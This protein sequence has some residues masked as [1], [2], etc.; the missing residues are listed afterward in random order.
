MTAVSSLSSL[1][2]LASWD[3][4]STLSSDPIQHSTAIEASNSIHVCCGSLDDELDHESSSES[5]EEKVKKIDIE[6]RS[7]DGVTFTLP[8]EFAIS[9]SSVIAATL[10]F[11]PKAR[12]VD[13][14]FVRSDEL[15]TIVAYVR[16]HRGK[17]PMPTARR[18]IGATVAS[19]CSTTYDAAL[20][21]SIL[22]NH[23]LF[24]MMKAAHYMDINPLLHLCAATIAFSALEVTIDNIPKTINSFL[25]VPL[26]SSSSSSSSSSCSK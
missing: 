13:L 15:R 4:S 12:S 11:D 3:S 26:S 9:A 6:L 14:P 1:A 7:S 8:R 10:S 18:A 23:Q 22:A 25:P 16:H 5:K 20:V 24:P 2:S 17:P 21:Q 19:I